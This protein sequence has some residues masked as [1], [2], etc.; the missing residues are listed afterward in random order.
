LVILCRASQSELS[1]GAKSPA[2]PGEP[3]QNLQEA[4]V[5]H[6]NEIQKVAICL[7]RAG[8]GGRAVDGGRQ[9]PGERTREGA[10]PPK[11]SQP[12]RKLPGPESGIR[13]RGRVPPRRDQ[14][15]RKV[16]E[17]GAH[18]D[19]GQPPAERLDPIPEPTGN[20][21]RGPGPQSSD[22]VA[23]RQWGPLEAGRE[24]PP[25][26]GPTPADAEQPAEGRTPEG[27]GH[28]EGDEQ[29]ADGGQ[30]GED[31]PTP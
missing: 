16:G 23:E 8:A 13:P 25:A 26:E 15:K 21:Q 4:V 31:D 14:G 28:P 17:R 19:D 5:W 30:L 20:P 12:E 22:G 27:E 24:G 6:E 3:N 29:P 7:A 2:G 10:S 18:P 9:P 11:G 1:I